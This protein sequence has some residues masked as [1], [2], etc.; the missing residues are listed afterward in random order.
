[1]RRGAALAALV[2]AA[3]GGGGDEGPR[4]WSGSYVSRMTGSSTDC[5]DET[6]PPP[7]TGFT[8]QVAQTPEGV[9]GVWMAPVI[10]L[11]GEFRGD[12][13]VA[14]SRFEHPLALDDSLLA[15]IEPADSFDVIAYEL[16]AAFADSG[17]TASYVIRTPDVRALVAGAP[18]LRCEYRYE[19]AGQRLADAAP[20]SPDTAP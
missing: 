4:N 2:L 20:L 1:M 14:T 9:T 12:S 19:L 18:T 17:Y 15:R 7:L 6:L 3:C 5:V 11:N 13:L 10:Q 8:M 16:H